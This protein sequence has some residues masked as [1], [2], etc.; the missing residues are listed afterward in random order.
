MDDTPLLST[1]GGISR[2]VGWTS[3]LIL[4]SMSRL[5]I[6]TTF[7]F[8]YL[9]SEGNGIIVAISRFD[10]NWTIILTVSLRAKA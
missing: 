2:C 4:S 5:V 6:I 7:I 8:W 10:H 9:F 3:F 1:G